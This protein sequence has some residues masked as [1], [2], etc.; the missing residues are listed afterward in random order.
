M[1]P[2]YTFVSHINGKNATVE[3]YPDHI[4]WNRKGSK[5]GY[6]AK[7]TATFGISMLG[8]K[9]EQNEM[10]PVR[11]ISTVSTKRDG[12]M[13]SKVVLHTVGG[14]L[15]F[16]VSHSEAKIVKEHIMSILVG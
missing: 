1:E 11:A 15:E 14:V 13:N 3:I 2:I 6:A 16:R 8:G 12:L 10:V 7:A 4:E 9:K 5:I